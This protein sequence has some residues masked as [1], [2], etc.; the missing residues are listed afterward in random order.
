MPGTPLSE[1]KERNEALV[2][3]EEKSSEFSEVVEERRPLIQGT[4]REDYESV[5]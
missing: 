5:N 2:T 3:N 1:L 4:P